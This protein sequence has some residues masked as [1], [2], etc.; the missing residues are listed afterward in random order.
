MELFLVQLYKRYLSVY[1]Y[2]QKK[3]KEKAHALAYAAIRNSLGGITCLFCVFGFS[4]ITGPCF[5]SV[6]LNLGNKRIYLY[7]MMALLIL[8]YLHFAKK[9]LK[10]VFSKVLAGLYGCGMFIIARLSTTYFCGQYLV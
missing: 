8:G 3:N 6:N 10:P 4:F 5:L 1:Y 9:Y 2:K 7:P